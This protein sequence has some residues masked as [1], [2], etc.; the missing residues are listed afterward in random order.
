MS[1]Y[2][3]TDEETLHR[4]AIEDLAR[5]IQKPIDV[6][7]RAYEHELARLKADAKIK[8]YLLLFTSRRTRETLLQQT[9]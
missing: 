4:F 3:D 5:E 9:A 7:T 8:D 6:V 2:D 1:L